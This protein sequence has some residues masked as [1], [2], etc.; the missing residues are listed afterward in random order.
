LDDF[1][2]LNGYCLTIFFVAMQFCIP[3]RPKGL[4]LLIPMAVQCVD[5]GG[6]VGRTFETPT[7]FKNI[8]STD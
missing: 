7:R 6:W 5:T 2:T 4:Q 3:V 8:S 1:V